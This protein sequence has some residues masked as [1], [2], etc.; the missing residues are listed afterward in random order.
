MRI[1]RSDDPNQRARQQ[2]LRAYNPV[3]Q[4]SPSSS[5]DFQNQQQAYYYP[6]QQQQQQQQQQPQVYANYPMN[7]DQQT[8]NYVA[9]PR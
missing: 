6:L 2:Q 3:N 7:Y 4:L 9:S 5:I 8:Q 1:C